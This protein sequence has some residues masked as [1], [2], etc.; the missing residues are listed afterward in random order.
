MNTGA[1]LLGTAAALA[2]WPGSVR[3]QTPVTADPS[4]L[5]V[6][7]EPSSA[8]LD[9]EVDPVVPLPAGA[10][11]QLEFSADAIVYDADADTVTATGRVRLRRG[12]ERLQADE[13][14]WNRRTG[15]VLANGTVTGVSANGDALYGERV[16]LTDTLR[17]GV[18]DNL[19]L[20]LEDGS[21]LAAN[22]GTRT[23]DI[24]RLEQVRY[25]AC[26]VVS[27]DGCP[28]TPSWSLSAVEV[29]Y[30]QTRRRIRYRGARLSL[31]GVVA[32][33]LP[34]L[35]QTIGGGS[36]SGLF[37]PN[38]GLGRSN[39]F[40]YS[41]P[42]Y[43][44]IA[45]NREL[46]ITPHL[47]TASLPM[48]QAEYRALTSNAAYRI[49]GYGTYS[50]LIPV[51]QG[52]SPDSRL[53]F[54]G[55]LDASGRAVL[56]PHWTVGASLRRTTD[57]TFL[58]RY[59]VNLDNRLRSV[60][61]AERFDEN[62]YLSI[63]GWATQELRTGF[64]QG[65][66][67]IALPAIDGRLRLPGLAGSDVVTVQVNSL[68]LLRSEGQDTGRAFAE[69]KWERRATTS[70]GQRL[71]F[72]GLARGDLYLARDTAAN[73]V[74]SYRGDEGVSGRAIALIAADVQWPFAGPLGGGFQRITPR[75]QVVATPPIANTS[76][77]NEDSRAFELEDV[78][79]F[80]LNRFP[81]FDR[82][83]DGAR[84]TAG[85]DY[86]Y[87]QTGFSLQTSVAQSVR[88]SDKPS[89]FPDGTG[90]TDNLSDYVARTNV[91]WRDWLS[92]TH[93]IR[94]DHQDL[95]V[96][97]NE[98]DVTA[99]SRTTYVT[100]GYLRLNRN[101][102]LEDQFDREEARVGGRVAFARYWSVFGSAIFDLTGRGEDP[103]SVSDGFQAI[104]HRIGI[105]YDDECLALG[106]TWRR[107]YLRQG[108][109]R[110]GNSFGF[111]LSL[112]GL[113]SR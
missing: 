65:Q 1:W 105:L 8:P 39:G 85:V 43:M 70:L 91:R 61:N 94:L 111:T 110:A 64:N 77:P 75:V 68:G 15:E 79:I 42:Y 31:F 26:P 11:E 107:N 35:S 87:R 109:S 96:R 18:V 34:G 45:P 57:R 104:R 100:A 36:A 28:R 55:Y 27:A 90:L 86:E 72:T 46:T 41:Q 3:A 73:P 7:D 5:G 56:S 113:G 33:P 54:R 30:D 89:L 66:Q 60:V 40:E 93:R 62:S 29:T 21:R 12:G 82:F 20:V 19:L 4:T 16:A 84:L 32:L 2:L 13:V 37:A 83:E 106:L 78:N 14:V 25:S 24:Y 58:R 63:A 9:N 10:P 99:G 92:L 22:R 112:R 47:Y 101:L 76:I 102:Q 67:P 49:A 95:A 51:A 23:G 80:A 88:L 52:G 108:D 48:I 17:D 50:R 103:L 71:T 97:R 6:P 81:G 69:A 74:A 38:V 44:R 59:D 98:V 53:E